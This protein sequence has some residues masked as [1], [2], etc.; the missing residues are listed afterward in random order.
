[1]EL[2]EFTTRLVSEIYNLA[3]RVSLV[4]SFCVSRVIVV[5][6]MSKEDIGTKNIHAQQSYSQN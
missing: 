2:Q 6:H 4:R 5:K 1:M 3:A